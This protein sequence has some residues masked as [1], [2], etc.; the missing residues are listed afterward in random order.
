[1]KKYFLWTVMAIV[2]CSITTFAQRPTRIVF[3]KGNHSAIISGTLLTYEGKREYLVRVRA[4][5]AMKV[6]SIGLKPVS[7]WIEGPAGSGYVQD[8]AAD[9]HGRSEIAPTARGDYKLTV[10]ECQKADAWRGTFRVKVTVR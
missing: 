6:E 3:N 7:I 10:Q 2:M 5:Q 4:G 9:C 8:L 1:M